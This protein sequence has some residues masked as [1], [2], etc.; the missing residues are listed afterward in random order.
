MVSYLTPHSNLLSRIE[1][2]LILNLEIIL[3]NLKDKTVMILLDNFHYLFINNNSNNEF[4]S[5]LSIQ[6][7]NLILKLVEKER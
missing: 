4:Y 6:I 2:E 7:V 1:T 5:K 3:S